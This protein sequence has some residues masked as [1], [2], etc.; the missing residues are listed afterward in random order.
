MNNFRAHFHTD[1]ARGKGHVEIRYRG[2]NLLHGD[3]YVSVGIW[4]DEYKSM[5]TNRAYDY[6]ERAYVISVESRVEDGAGVV[7]QAAEWFC[8]QDQED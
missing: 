6:H 2:L 7:F 4:P 8:A 1:L 5:V 3:Y